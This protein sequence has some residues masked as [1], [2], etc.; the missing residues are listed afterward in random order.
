MLL[1]PDDVRG[2]NDTHWQFLRV[3]PEDIKAE[4]LTRPCDDAWKDGRAFYWMKNKAQGPKERLAF[5][6]TGFG[7]TVS[8]KLE[9]KYENQPMG[10]VFAEF[11]GTARLW[12]ADRKREEDQFV[13]FNCG[14]GL[15]HARS[16]GRRSDGSENGAEA[17]LMKN[18]KGA[19][20]NITW[21]ISSNIGGETLKITE[22]LW[23]TFE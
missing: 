6:A 4:P 11:M 14:T 20:S 18:V 16:L 10:L 9:E 7:S 5:N 3:D 15:K 21:T 13:L 12:Y 23:E 22:P 2:A 8:T 19:E 17:V 1:Y